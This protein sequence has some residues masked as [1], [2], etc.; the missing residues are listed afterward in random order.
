MTTIEGRGSFRPRAV[1]DEACSAVRTRVQ[2]PF[3]DHRRNWDQ[4]LRPGSELLGQ[5]PPLAPGVRD[6]EHRIDD[7]AQVVSVLRSS[8]GG[9]YQQGF[10][11]LPL[12]VGQVTWIGHDFMVSVVAPGALAK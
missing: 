2:V 4:T 7:V 12:G 6:V 10:E 1:R 11:E 8:F 5:E 3:L 9:N